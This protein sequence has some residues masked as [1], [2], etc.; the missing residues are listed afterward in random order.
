MGSFGY[1]PETS[2]VWVRPSVDV[3]AE[4][5]WGH[6]TGLQIGL[7]PLPGPRGLVRV[8]APY[9]GHARDRLLNFIAIEP[10]P[11]GMTERGFSELE[12]SSLDGERG[13]RL[14]GMDDPGGSGLSGDPG[15]PD[16][17]VRGVVDVRDGI[18]W[19]TVFIGV[20]RFDNGADVYLR[21]SFR[22]DRPYEVALAAFRSAGSVELD[23]LTLTATMGNYARLRCLHLAGR[24]AS[25][26]E[27]W[28]GFSGDGFT[29][30]ARF[31]LGELQRDEHGAAIVTATTDERDPTN[32]DYADGTHDHWKYSGGR[33]IQ[34]W[35][36]DDPQPD[37]EVLVN[38]RHCYWASNSPIPGGVSF[39]NFEFAEPFV[40]GQEYVFSVGPDG[41][42]GD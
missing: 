16:R 6:A 3:P 14:W 23:R 30:H 37:L 13:K 28:P 39:E 35:R 21:A 32:A 40:P 29:E 15:D 8:F 24:V 26:G 33:A 25:P 7:S 12:W 10:A 11:A 17:P 2:R 27:L 5:R 36:C 31:G 20:E 4:P 18:E 38:G 41:L 42:I 9:L 22:A 1:L 19:L 34:G